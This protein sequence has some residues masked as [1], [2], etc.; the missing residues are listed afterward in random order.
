MGVAVFVGIVIGATPLYGFHLLLC[1]AAA[2]LFRLNKLTVYLV[3][4]IS[5]PLV[6]PLLL[7][8]EVMIGEWILHGTVLWLDPS[9]IQSLGLGTVAYRFFVSALVG[10]LAVGVGLGAPLGLATTLWL[11]RKRSEAEASDGSSLSPE[12]ELLRD[13]ER[14]R[15]STRAV[16]E[17]L[18]LAALE[19]GESHFR[20]TFLVQYTTAKISMDPVYRNLVS[21]L[22]QAGTVID[23]GTGFGF[24]PLLLGELYPKRSGQV[25]GFDYDQGKVETGQ[26]AAAVLATSNVQLEVGDAV[27]RAPGTA[28]A[29]CLIDVLHYLDQEKQRSLVVR[30]VE[31]LSPGGILVIRDMPLKGGLGALVTRYGERFAMW[32]GLNRGE[33]VTPVD[34]DQLHA[35]MESMGLL[36][37]EHAMATGPLAD[38]L[39][40]GSVPDDSGGAAT[41]SG[42]SQQIH[43]VQDGDS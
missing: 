11:R 27:D 1:L 23:I 41:H 17:A 6:A 26:A 38:R 4:N 30:C 8:V 39:W 33:R 16:A 36:V 18:R 24:L 9:N 25:L 12:D 29:I 15:A 7:A 22:P 37:T 40:V 19:R 28:A 5:N 42:P 2:T 34:S 20:R 10:S 21:L 32:V 3:A 14:F 31:A 13:D 43:G 35:A